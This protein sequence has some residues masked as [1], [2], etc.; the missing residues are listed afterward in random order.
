[1]DV[2]QILALT[3]MAYEI[4]RLCFIHVLWNQTLAVMTATENEKN[5]MVIKEKTNQNIITKYLGI[6]YLIFTIFLIFT[7][8]FRMIG[9]GILILSIVS[10]IVLFPVVKKKEQFNAK[11]FVI[12]L[13]DTILTIMLLSNIINPLTLFN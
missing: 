10:V 2:I 11:I 1:M 7:P 13:I 6:V 5:G 3:F 12:Q 4:I 9:L 8:E